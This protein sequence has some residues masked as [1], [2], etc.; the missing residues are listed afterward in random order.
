MSI[1]LNPLISTL[2]MV[3]NIYSFVVIISA[4]LSFVRPDPNNQ[5]V[6]VVYRLTEPIFSIIRR[7][8]PFTVYA[9]IDFSPLIVLL[10]I[11]FLISLL[12]NLY[13]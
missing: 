3:L 1:V 8:L 2:I 4:F 9:G 11:N 10:A 5:I 6:Q 12:S 7:K 13:L